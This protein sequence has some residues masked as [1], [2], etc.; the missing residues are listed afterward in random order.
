MFCPNC[1]KENVDEAKFCTFCGNKI[2]N[3]QDVETKD[4]ESEE[5]EGNAMTTISESQTVDTSINTKTSASSITGF[6][7]SIVGLLFE[8][9]ICG[10]LGIIFSSIGMK[11]TSSSEAVKGKGLAI[12][13]LVMS[14][15]AVVFAL[16]SSVV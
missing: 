5:A 13:G 16:I 8:P 2:I 11:A 4:A 14:I 15:V 10:I 7:L 1:G 12:A 6:V 3:E 9:F